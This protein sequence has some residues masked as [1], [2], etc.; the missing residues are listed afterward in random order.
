MHEKTFSSYDRVRPVKAGQIFEGKVFFMAQFTNQATLSYNNAVINSNIAVGEI[1]EVLSATKTAVGDSYS[2]N[3]NVTYVI[4]IVNAGAA[5]FTGLSLTDDLGAYSFGTGTVTP[6]TYVDSTVRYYENGI[7][8]TAPAVTVGPP[9]TISGISVPAGGNAIII[10]EAEVNQFAPA[11]LESVIT[12]TAV[13]SGGGITPI[14]VTETISALSEPLLTITKSVSPVPV[15]ENGRLTYTFL[16]Q[17]TGNTPI[18][19]TENAVIT[20]IFDPILSNLAVVFN[21]TAWTEGP[22]YAYDEATGT[23]T[24]VGGN[25]TVPA[26]TYSQDPT[27]GAWTVNPGVSTLVI[28]GTV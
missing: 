20:D 21:G 23:F 12:N 9:L 18:E 1:L 27:T 17:N 28:S 3:D 2:Q 22:D 6:L 15:T 26:A 10:Y 25:I 5:A 4:S 11:S 7:L 14:T 13:L 24:T 8:Q 19:A 16:I